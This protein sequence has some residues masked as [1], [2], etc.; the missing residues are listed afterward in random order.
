MT[1][2]YEKNIVEI[3]HEYTS[4]LVDITTPL[5]YEGLKSMY[6]KAKIKE[7]EKLAEKKVNPTLQVPSV[8]RIFQVFL[9]GLK[10]MNNETIANETQRIRSKSGCADYFDDL[11]K[12]VIK[13]NIILLTFN[14]SN[15]KNVIV[16]QKYHERV[17]TEDFI[18]KCY[19]SSG[20]SI[21]NNPEI[22]WDG[23]SPLQIKKNQREICFI[24]QKCINKSIRKML[25]MRLLVTEYLKNDYVDPLTQ[26]P[27]YRYDRV[28]NMLGQE[29]QQSV[30]TFDIPRPTRT[31]L[32]MD[33]NEEN[34]ALNEFKEDADADKDEGGM[35]M[36]EFIEDVKSQYSSRSNSETNNTI[37]GENVEDHIEHV[38]VHSTSSGESSHG[39][40]DSTVNDSDVENKSNKLKMPDA[41]HNKQLLNI[42]KENPTIQQK[43]RP[44]KKTMEFL[45]DI[46]K[47]MQR[48]NGDI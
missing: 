48:I 35:S 36:E 30:P 31:N 42:L 45:G 22:F 32:L 14:T 39:N 9:K 6:S 33:E 28:Q 17:T 19:I 3:K 18:H 15:K 23:Y 2:Y 29:N 46:T 37:P 5:I 40:D 25:P 7:Q 16:E 20:W 34:K 44:D 24:I 8:L 4:L 27:K 41:S 38:S 13:S 11:I 12:A 26:V 10:D 47:S 43:L 1:H 21:F